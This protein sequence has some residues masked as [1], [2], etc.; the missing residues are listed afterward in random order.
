MRRL[1]RRVDELLSVVGDDQVYF[2]I[3]GSDRVVKSPLLFVTLTFRHDDFMGIGESIGRRLNEFMSKV[4]KRYK[5][6]FIVARVFQVHG[7]GYLHVHL[8]LARLGWPYT[9]FTGFR[10]VS[11]RDGRVSY[12]LPSRV[13]SW[14]KRCWSYGFSDFQLCSSLKGALLYL[15][16]YMFRSD[17]NESRIPGVDVKTLTYAVSWIF[18]LRTFSM[19]I[20]KLAVLCANIQKLKSRLDSVMRNSNLAVSSWKLM[21][22]IDRGWICCPCGDFEVFDGYPVFLLPNG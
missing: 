17:G 18:R 7:D 22:V 14:F 10:H 19:N 9:W 11:K 3:H 16:R 13:C 21:G 15:S 8:L 2:D 12:R 5:D 6:V 20:R 1:R 4:R